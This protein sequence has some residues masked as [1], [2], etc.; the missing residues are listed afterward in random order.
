MTTAR[1]DL[2]RFEHPERR[3]NQQPV[4]VARGGEG[5]EVT[6]PGTPPF[7]PGNSVDAD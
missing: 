2:G 5:L 7:S 6:T 4:V 3:G 1:R